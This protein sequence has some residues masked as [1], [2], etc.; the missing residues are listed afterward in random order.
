ME[1]WGVRGALDRS[2]KSAGVY[3]KNAPERWRALDTPHP[4]PGPSPPQ[5]STKNS[6]FQMDEDKQQYLSRW[7]PEKLSPNVRF[8]IST[9]EG[10]SSHQTIRVFKTSPTEIICG[11]LNQESREVGGK[12]HLSN[13]V[14]FLFFVYSWDPRKKSRALYFLATTVIL[15]HRHQFSDRYRQK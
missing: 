5:I 3:C 4:T 7:V 14:K 15:R 6:S 13:L 12:I 1:R 2:F 9:I 11:P 8:V 10:T